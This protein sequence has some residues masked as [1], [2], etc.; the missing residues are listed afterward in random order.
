[1]TTNWIESSINIGPKID[2]SAIPQANFLTGD[3]YMAYRDPAGHYHNGLFRV[4]HTLVMQE[5][6][7]FYYSFVA[8]T[9]SRDLVDWSQPRILTPKDHRLN[10]SSP[11]NIIRYNDEWV[12]CFQTYPMKSQTDR[13]GDETARLF[14]ACSSD[15]D[16]WS[17]PE[18]I[19]VKGPYVSIEDMGRMIDPYLLADKDQPNKWWCFY[20]QNGA[21]M[22]R[23][24]DLQNWTYVGNIDSGEN[25]CLIVDNDEYVLFHSPRNGIGIKRSKNL[26]DWID[27]QLLT[28]G[29]KEWEWAAGRITA[30]HVLDLRHVDEVGKFVM[31]FHGSV[32]TDI[33]PKE[34]HG[35]A[36]LGVAWSD[37]LLNWDWPHK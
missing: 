26:K 8:M 33:Q 13:F 14:T 12:L 18:L 17:Q 29:Q 30:G 35:Q 23:S 15:L 22:S 3:N 36:S 21:S 2:W 32:S 9:T 11:G 27:H 28:F 34:T 37:D 10:Y 19:K 1:M 24:Q 20:K 5:S 6:D 4:F 16:N 7:G 31:F 25:V